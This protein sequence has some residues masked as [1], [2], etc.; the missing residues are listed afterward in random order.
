[1]G[2]VVQSYFNILQIQ[3]TVGGFT[4]CLLDVLYASCLLSVFGLFIGKIIFFALNR[5]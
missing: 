2:S 3:F 4:F 1:M 5:R